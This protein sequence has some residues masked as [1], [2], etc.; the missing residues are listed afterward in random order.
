MKYDETT[1]MQLTLAPLPALKLK[2]VSHAAFV[3]P[4]LRITH[5]PTPMVAR[6]SKNV[7][8]R[9]TLRPYRERVVS[10]RL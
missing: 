10:F 8:R 3:G 7:I 9:I 5:I 2:V 1:F 6:L 4:T